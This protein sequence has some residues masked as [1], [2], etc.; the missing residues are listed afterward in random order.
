MVP[1][2]G[3]SS[4]LLGPDFVAAGFTPSLLGPD[5]VVVG[6]GSALLDTDDGV[7]DGAAGPAP[8]FIGTDDGV[9][10]SAGSA[11]EHTTTTLRVRQRDRGQ[12][13]L[14]VWTHKPEKRRW[15][16]GPFWR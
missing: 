5:F 8:A 1:E 4:A 7:A 9:A 11:T 13:G 2:L 12:M 10:R 16:S 6:L 15:R 3:L 14:E